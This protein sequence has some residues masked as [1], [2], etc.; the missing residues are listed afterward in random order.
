MRH[1]IR[2][3]TGA[4]AGTFYL[5]LPIQVLQGLLADMA[6]QTSLTRVDLADFFFLLSSRTGLQPTALQVGIAL[7]A[8]GYTL[9]LA[10][11]VR[12]AP[13][14]PPADAVRT[15]G[16]QSPSEER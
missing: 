14:A 11:L 5:D 9:G 10:R 13:A 7:A 8:V 16:P 6:N 4:L 2:R 12:P 15:R 3:S 1:W